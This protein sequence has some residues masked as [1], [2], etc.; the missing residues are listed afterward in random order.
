[1][2]DRIQVSFCYIPQA[3]QV[4]EFSIDFADGTTI[5]Q[6]LAVIQQQHHLATAQIG[7]VGV[8]GR[9]SKPTDLLR[10]GDRLEC[11]RPLLV[12]PK[13]ARRK[14]FKRQGAKRSGLFAQRRPGSVPGY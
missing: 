5:G 2:A 10:Q 8:W 7:Y 9:L 14:R 3:G 11:Y 6:A 13:V 12:D 1:M 4:L